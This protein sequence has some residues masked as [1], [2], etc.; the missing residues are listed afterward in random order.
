MPKKQTEK[1]NDDKSSAQA[2]AYTPGLKIKESEV[3]EK[4]RKLPILGEVL[5]NE[6]DEVKNDT[7]VAQTFVPGDP[8]IIDAANRW[9][10]IPDVIQ[11]CMLK[12]IGSLV[13]EGETIAKYTAFFGLVKKSLESPVEGTIE[14]VSPITGQIIITGSPIPVYI[15]A[16]VPGKVKEVEPR[17]GAVIET[18]GVFIQGIFGIGGE[19]YGTIRVPIDSAKEV[20][21]ADNITSDMKDCIII[22]GSLINLDT[23]NKAIQVGAAGIIGGG[24]NSDDLIKHMGTEIGV[25]ITGEEEGITMIITEGFGNMTMHLKTFEILKKFEGYKASINGETQIRA[26]VIRPEVIIPH[27]NRI[28]KSTTALDDGMVSGTKIRIIREPYFGAIAKVVSLP[29]EL[30]MMESGS[31]VRVLEAELESGEKVIVPRANVEIIEE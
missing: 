18:H 3:V 16:Y 10:V 22:A 12:P 9:G 11:E 31:Y 14:T 15:D 19:K 21:T 20:L 8:F 27:E 1:N 23:L 7:R 6:N 25:A 24:I 5:V 4:E 2:F 30:Q 17:E 29:V 26:G 28:T 13:K